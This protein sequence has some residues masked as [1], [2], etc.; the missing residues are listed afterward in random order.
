MFVCPRLCFL[1]PLLLILVKCGMMIRIFIRYVP[2]T[3]I[4]FLTQ[5]SS[6]RNF[7]CLAGIQG[8]EIAD[9]LAR[10]GSVRV[11][12]GPEPALGGL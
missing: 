1:K 10:G 8:N 7:V 12:V 2:G 4:S 6:H 5:C 11:F 3:F 9:E